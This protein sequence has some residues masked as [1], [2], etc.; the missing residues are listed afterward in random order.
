MVGRNNPIARIAKTWLKAA[1]TWH[2]PSDAPPIFLMATPRGG[3]TWVTEVICRQR[4]MRY[5]AEPLNIRSYGVGSAL[6]VLKWEDMWDV[7]P[8]QLEDYFQRLIKGKIRMRDATP[9]R[10]VGRYGFRFKTERTALKVIH[11]ATYHWQM[12]EQRLNARVVVVLRHPIATA[13]SREVF[14]ALDRIEESKFFTALSVPQREHIQKVLKSGTHLE[15]GV[16]AWCLHNLPYFRSSACPFVVTYEELVLAPAVAVKK[17]CDYCELDDS[18]AIMDSLNY[19]S[20]TT[21]K[22]D[23]ATQALFEEDDRL[24]R[25][26]KIVTKWQARVDASDAN[27]AMRSLDIFNMQLYRPDS[28]LP[29]E[30]LLHNSEEVLRVLASSAAEPEST[31]HRRD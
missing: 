18:D 5:V 20:V 15:K 14:P 8:E 9:F 12:L 30:M 6:G 2:F 24:K 28:P 3:S 27:K 31:K 4:G 7:T 22:S 11:G 13:I 10:H 1:I 21:R 19:A 17:L 23:S 26:L 16:L 25:S 29:S